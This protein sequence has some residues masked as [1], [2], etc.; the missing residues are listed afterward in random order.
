MPE[1]VVDRYLEHLLQRHADLPDGHW[2]TY[3]TDLDEE[4]IAHFGISLV[5][6]DG[7]C[8]EAGDTRVCF[9][10]QSVSKPMTF[11]LA[12]DR[13]GFDVVSERVDVEP[14]GV[15]FN[16]LTL[17]PETGRPL[18]PMVNAGAIATTSLRARRARRS[19]RRSA[20][21]STCARTPARACLS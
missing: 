5:T 7:Q 10:I 20:R 16:A 12:L 15:S 14:T 6:V 18:N 1:L 13:H 2:E 4:Q 9:P 3:A 8:Y 17:D 11:S 19:R 21:R